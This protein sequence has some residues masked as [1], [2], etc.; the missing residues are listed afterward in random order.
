MFWRGDFN[1]WPACLVI[2][3]SVGRKK[4]KKEMFLVRMNNKTPTRGLELVKLTHFLVSRWKESFK[5]WLSQGN[6]SFSW[7]AV[8]FSSTDWLSQCLV[9][10]LECWKV[11][12]NYEI[13][14]CI[15]RQLPQSV[16]T[17]D[18]RYPSE[19][20]AV[21]NKHV[22]W[23]LSTPASHFGKYGINVGVLIIFALQSKPYLAIL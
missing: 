13:I 8:S 16:R 14:L 20:T 17:A 4:K 6:T 21:L 10:S 5:K 12:L 3:G 7:L 15:E 22:S 1:K 18:F 9:S 23:R 2:L 11:K 19:E